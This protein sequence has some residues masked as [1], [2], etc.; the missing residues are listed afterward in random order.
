MLQHIFI[1]GGPWEVRSFV[2]FLSQRANDS[3]LRQASAPCTCKAWRLHRA[4]TKAHWV[5]VCKFGT[6]PLGLTLEILLHI[7]QKNKK[8]TFVND[9]LAKSQILRNGALPL[10]Q[11]Y[12]R[13]RLAFWV[14][15]PQRTGQRLCRHQ[16]QWKLWRLGGTVGE[17]SSSK[18]SSTDGGNWWFSLVVSQVE[19]YGKNGYPML[20][21]M[22]SKNWLLY[23]DRSLLSWVS[24]VVSVREVPA[25]H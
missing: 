2:V 20:S 15:I 6:L 21:L 22:Y 14:K 8:I 11:P 16:V 12:P 25:W 1:R 4:W 13:P 17:D 9:S 23:R 10:R 18:R 24:L 7:F 3:P 5:E 19:I